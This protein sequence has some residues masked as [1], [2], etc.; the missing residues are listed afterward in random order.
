[1]EDKPLKHAKIVGCS[2]I[3]A[4]MGV[5]IET[6]VHLGAK[7]KWAAC[8]IFSTQNEVAAALAERNIS[9]YAWR[10]ESEDDFWWCIDQCFG[11]GSDNWQPNM[12]FD[13][14]GDATAIMIKKYPAIAKCVRGV[15]EE[16]VTGVHRLYQL[17][18]GGKLTCPAMNVND[19]IT[20]SKYIN[21]YCQKVFLS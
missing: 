18:K 1:M 5:M 21:F 6:L 10:G 7:V 4:Q 9:V 15:V 8:N 20:K 16:S 13:D 12:V 17:F 3:N 19:A 11:S 2:H 14:G